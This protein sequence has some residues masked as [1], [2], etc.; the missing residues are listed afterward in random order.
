MANG[1]FGPT[2]REV[3]SQIQRDAQLRRH[4]AT[5]SMG[6]T[7]PLQRMA[8]QGGMQMGEGFGGLLNSVTGTKPPE[9]ERAEKRDRAI[10]TVM[11]KNPE[12]PEEMMDMQSSEFLRMG[13]FQEAYDAGT[14]RRELAKE[15]EELS[16]VKALA[17]MRKAQA[18][19]ELTSEEII[20]GKGEDRASKE[21]IASIRARARVDSAKV[22]GTT[23]AGAKSR[24]PG[25]KD[26]K[27]ATDIL[28]QIAIPNDISGGTFLSEVS[29]PDQ[30]ARLFAAEAMDIA[31]DEGRDVV[32]V[33][34]ELASLERLSELG[35][36]EEKGGLWDYVGAAYTV[37]KRKQVI[38]E[39]M[40]QAL[41]NNPDK[42][43]EFDA[44]YGEGAAAKILGK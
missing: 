24:T 12:S 6:F 25:T 28:N 5:Q 3:M 38:P 1:I 37:G 16:A 30:L 19:G 23:K 26:V 9:L 7:N 10:A 8:F 15:E 29:D 32:D 42:R 22:R 20:A 40:K 31:A 4:Q 33:M 44:K 21:R 34:E 18:A 13:L 39:K 35:L 27:L 17:S 2:G 43:D 36:I 41:I 11:S 14:R